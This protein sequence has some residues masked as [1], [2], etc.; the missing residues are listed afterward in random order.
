MGRSLEPADGGATQVEHIHRRNSQPM[1]RNHQ[2]RAYIFACIAVITIPPLFLVS[3]PAETGLT[4]VAP[5][6]VE[7]HRTIEESTRA[8]EP[9]G[10]RS[11][12]LPPEVTL[13]RIDPDVLEALQRTNGPSWLGPNRSISNATD[14]FGPATPIA[15]VSGMWLQ[16]EPGKYLWRTTIRSTGA[17][18]VRAHFEDFNVDGRVYVYETGTNSQDSYLGP[19]EGLGPQA[20]GDF[21]TDLVSAE[22]IT[23]EFLPTDQSSVPTAIPFAIREIAHIINLVGSSVS[24]SER[25]GIYSSPIVEPRARRIVGCHLDVSCYT[26]WQDRAYPSTVLLVMTKSDGTYSCTGVLVNTRYETDRHLLML[27]AAHCIKD[28]TTASNTVVYWDY[29]T[30]ECYGTLPYNYSFARTYGADLVLTRGPDRSF[31]FSLLR[32]DPQEVYHVTGVRKMGWDPNYVSTN[33]EVVNVSHPTGAFKRIAFG[34]TTSVS[35]NGLSSSGFGS[36]RWDRGT[37]EGGSSGSGVFLDGGYLIGI[38][39]GSNRDIEPCDLE[40]RT[41]HNRFDKIYP[42]IESFLESEESLDVALDSFRPQLIHVRLGQ[43]GGTVTLMTT[44]N[45]GYTLDGRIFVSGTSVIGEGRREYRLTLDAYGNW[46][47]TFVPRNVIVSLGTSGESLT[48]VSTEDGSSLL[49]HRSI[50]SGDIVSSSTGRQYR[51]TQGAS[52]AWVATFLPATI[53]VALGTSGDTV[54]IQTT[55]T[56]GYTIGGALVTSG[57]SLT[58]GGGDEYTLTLDD[59]G[60]WTATLA[61]SSIEVF[62]TPSTRLLLERDPMGRFLYDDL[63]VASGSVLARGLGDAYRLDRSYDGDWDATP[64]LGNFQPSE[65][66][67]DI[68]TLVGV[69]VFGYAGDNYFASTAL[70]A[71]PYYV[72]TDPQGNVLVSDSGNHRVRKIDSQGIIRTI[73]GTGQP[74]SAGDGGLAAN[75]QLRNPRGI[76][77]DSNGTLYIVDAGNHRIRVI[78]TS[79]IIATLAGTGLAGFN[80]DDRLAT[81]AQLS[82]PSGVTTDQFG[83]VF[84]ADSGNHRIRMIS[85]DYISTVAGIGTGGFSGDGGPAISA[86]IRVPTAITTDL[87]GNVYFADML[88]HRVRY[89]DIDG[90]ITTV[91]GTGLAGYSGDGHTNSNAQ[92]DT[93]AGI[94]WDWSNGL[95]VADRKANVVRAVDPRGIVSTV[96]GSRMSGSGGD[97]GPAELAQLDSPTGIAVT[98]G[99]NL[100]IADTRNQ[101][102]RRLTPHRQVIPP[103]EV[104]TQSL[105]AL[106]DSGQSLRLWRTGNRFDYFGEPISSG[107]TVFGWNGERYRLSQLAT[108]RW[109]ASLV[110]TN[111]AEAASEYRQ[112]ALRGDANAQF[113][114]GWLYFQGLGVAE[115]NAAALRW[116]TLA[117]AQGH[118]ESQTGLGVIYREG[119]GVFVNPLEA[120]NWFRRSANQGSPSGLHYLGMMFYNGEGVIRNPSVAAQFFRLAAFADHDEAQ[121]WLGFLFES[122]NGVPQ[123]YEQSNK[124]YLLS[125]EQGNPNSQTSLGSSYYFGKGVSKD[126]AQ[127]AQWFSRAAQ[128]GYPNAQSFLGFLYTQGHGVARN[129]QESVRWFRRAAEQGDAY[130]QW[131]LGRAYARGVGIASD[132]VTAHVWLG[133]AIANGEDRA[134]SDLSELESRMSSSEIR[135]AQ[136]LMATCRDSGYSRCP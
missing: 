115:D 81:T 29:Q 75:A 80:G 55:E 15:S 76:H 97:G 48:L 9:V 43:R 54:E 89:I 62:L 5:R 82:N 64:F 7:R 67:Y 127:A 101:R 40:Y 20:D 17:S 111:F 109:Q 87:I 69:G 24:P 13:P 126:H 90:V 88:N 103:H 56:G 135:R 34:R 49:N 51:L 136:S 26:E 122:G 107:D 22:S 83:N 44:K 66:H 59:E 100:L 133:L 116:F 98:E 118:A 117:A 38:M 37:T 4:A 33:T 36:A 50:S 96:G 99:G 72:A 25:K 73:V 92:I 52:G 112:D 121:L 71:N 124:W 94:A 53:R 91:L 2:P 35:W 74:G 84:I 30:T 27:T 31:D 39:G 65:Q 19:Y 61:T 104:P 46:Q 60:L 128:Q 41:Y 79:G 102:V 45:G 32:L 1:E 47:A 28:K 129:N 12:P 114:L 16:V 134:K 85:G 110:P 57:T 125:A 58:T 95:Y 10:R 78:H 113:E 131:S 18:A 105:V 106:G 8:P 77:V 21:W 14:T 93:P 86:L 108:G 3:L 68:E 11:L 132:S 123:S 42:E 23:V 120:L 6:S 70:I 63:T 119:Y 130:G